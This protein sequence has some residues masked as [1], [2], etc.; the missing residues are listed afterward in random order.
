MQTQIDDFFVQN[1]QAFGVEQGVGRAVS[2]LQ[3]ARRRHLHP[4]HEAS[5]SRGRG[6]KQKP[7]LHGHILSPN[8]TL[9]NLFFVREVSEFCS[10]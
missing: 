10:M 3:H 8:L 6:N 2:A 5:S 1:F 7:E 9:P 4:R